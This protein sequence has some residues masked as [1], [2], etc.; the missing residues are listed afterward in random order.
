MALTPEQRK[1]AQTIL[2]VGKRM[3]ASKKALKAA[4]ETGL[5][6]SNLRNL[7]YGDRDSVGVF[8]QRP[9]QGWKGL[10]NVERAAKEFYAQ[11]I[12]NAPKYGTAGQLAQ[13]V[14]RSAFPGRYDQH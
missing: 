4:L 11:A 9:S 10:T 1:N 5:T 14:Q 13:S 3:G 7:S 2:K 8:Q 6:E 12:P